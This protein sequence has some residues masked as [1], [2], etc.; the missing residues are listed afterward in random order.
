[1]VGVSL[2]R[3]HTN[4]SADQDQVPTEQELQARFDRLSPGDVIDVE[5]V[6]NGKT[7]V[8]RQSEVT[9]RFGNHSKISFSEPSSD[10]LV[11]LG[12][13]IT[14]QG[15]RF[16]SQGAWNGENSPW[17]TAVVHVIGS[18]CSIRQARIDGVS[19]V[20]IGI[21]GAGATIADCDLDGQYPANKWTGTETGHFGVAWDPP[22]GDSTSYLD[23]HGCTLRNLVQGVGIGN[24]AREGRAQA[25][26]KNNEFSGCHNHGVYAMSGEQHR[27]AQNVFTDCQVPIVVTGNGHEISNNKLWAT[28]ITN[29]KDGQ[30]LTGIDVREAKSNTVQ[31]NTIVGRSSAANIGISLDSASNDSVDGNIVEDNTILM[32]GSGLPIIRVGQRS[33]SYSGNHIL[34]NT[35]V[36]LDRTESAVI[37]VGPLVGTTVDST[38]NSVRGNSLYIP[39]NLDAIVANPQ[40]TAL[41]RNRVF[42]Y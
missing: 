26:I 19:R 29:D 4:T 10:G 38:G 41:A 25:H 28:D 8:I 22:G 2:A 13:R 42:R 20:G 37:Q 9:I 24:F 30:Q 12:D 7:L 21:R 33:K 15:G 32:S 6:Y 36:A 1:M 16:I 27:V 11:L 23:V 3:Y 5:G 31:S 18:R 39:H 34:S 14:I 40:H 35:V 17:K